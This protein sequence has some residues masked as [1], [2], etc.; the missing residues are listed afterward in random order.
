MPHQI[1]HQTHL[2]SDDDQAIVALCTPRGSGAIALIRI[3][4]KNA[5]SVATQISRL[6]SGQSLSTQSTHTI[7]HGHV[8]DPQS[9][10]VI[11]EVL[12]LLMHGPRTFTGHDTV[13]ITSHNNPFIIEQIINHAVSC[14]ARPARQGEFTK[15]SFLS[16]KIDLIQAEAIHDLITS[17]TEAALRQSMSTLQGSLSQALHMIE[18]EIVNLLSYVEASFEFLDEEQRDFSFDDSIQA[19]TEQILSLISDLK[20]NFTHAKQ[21]KEGVRVAILGSVNAGKSTLFNALL[22]KERAIVADIAGTTRDSI[23]SGMFI[24]GNFWLLVDTAGMRQTDDIIEQQGIERS[25]QQAAHADVIILLIDGSTQLTD[26]EQEQYRFLIH[27]YGHKIILV[28]N[29]IEDGL[30]DC[31]Q[32]AARAL[33]G[34]FEAPMCLRISAKQLRGVHSVTDAVDQ[35]IQQLFSQLNSPFL[36]NQRQYNLLTEIDVRLGNIANSYS[37]GLHYELIAYNLKDLL[38]KVSELTG[39]NVSEKVLDTVFGEFCIGK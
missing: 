24:H 9:G 31:S 5:I 25:F 7:H 35:K 3:S 20:S 23:E 19:R 28:F 32:E 29:K 38:E 30:P 37:D 26:A 33:Y 17:Q 16:G 11:D 4:G 39:K 15:R 14:G 2:L 6:S 18:N 12:F 34:K 21:V 22:K 36:L 8:I 1:N 13:E 27:Q 10:N